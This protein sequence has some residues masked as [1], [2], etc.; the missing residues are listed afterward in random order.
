M[1]SCFYKVLPSSHLR[2]VSDALF[3]FQIIL[4]STHLSRDPEGHICRQKE[5]VVYCTLFFCNIR[6]K[7][8]IIKK[9]TSAFMFQLVRV[10]F[11]SSIFV[12]FL[13]VFNFSTK[14]IIRLFFFSPSGPNPQ[15]SL[16]YIPSGINRV[17]YNPSVIPWVSGNS[18]LAFQLLT[19]LCLS[20]CWLFV[21]AAGVALDFASTIRVLPAWVHTQ[22]YTRVVECECGCG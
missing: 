11:F 18:R 6:T 16:D 5:K 22:G 17:S 10:F 14:N 21:S 13:L 1:F 20:A 2:G 9:K 3:C 7:I 4:S 15:K 8:I 19:Y 12:L